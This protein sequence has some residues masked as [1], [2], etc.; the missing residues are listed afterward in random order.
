[1]LRIATIQAARA[2]GQGTEL[3]AVAEEKPADLVVV[4]GNPPRRI[5][6]LAA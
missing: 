5:A 6:D 4:D 2:M 3:G 1:M